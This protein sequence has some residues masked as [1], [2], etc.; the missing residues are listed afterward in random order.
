MPSSGPLSF[1]RATGDP[2]ER[3]LVEVRAAIELVRGGH[4]RRV[5]L[6]GL[7]RPEA[8]AGIGAALAGE[9]GVRFRLERSVAGLASVVVWTEPGE[10][11]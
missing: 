2:G 9:A 3:A 8:I 6:T 10:I 1:P 11:P 5:A 4:A 7:D